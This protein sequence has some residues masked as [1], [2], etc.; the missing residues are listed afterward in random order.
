MCNYAE[1]AQ[2]ASDWPGH[3]WF[4]T[5]KIFKRGQVYLSHVNCAEL[6]ITI[7]IHTIL[8]LFFLSQKVSLLHGFLRNIL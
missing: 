8:L 5:L 4:C 2:L 1:A 3:L 6:N 7:K